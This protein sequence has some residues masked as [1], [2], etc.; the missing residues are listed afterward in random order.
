VM[1]FDQPVV[2]FA[3]VGAHVRADGRLVFACWQ[4]VNDNPWHV[5]PVL[6]PF[7]APPP[8]P[9]PGRSPTGPFAFGDPAL[10]VELLGS[11]GWGDVERTGYA[12]TEVVGRTAIVGDE[13]LIFRE[14]APGDLAVAREA[15][16]RHIDRFERDDGRLEIPIAFQIFCARRH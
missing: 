6:A 1:F 8:P 3:N 12:R 9:I 2:A 7:Q 11:A 10:V 5:G 16:G 4:R 13:E 15:V 14:V